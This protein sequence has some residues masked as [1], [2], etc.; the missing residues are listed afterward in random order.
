MDINYGTRENDQWKIELPGVRFAEAETPGS[1]PHAGV[2]DVLVGYKYRYLEEA[3]SGFSAS[4][5][6]QFLLPMGNSHLGIGDGNTEF[7]AEFQFGKHY[8][9]EKLF[10]YSQA[11]FTTCFNDQDFN[12][13]D[14]GIAADWK[15][16][17]KFE[18]MSDI[19]G[20]AFPDDHSMDY[21]FVE[22]GLAY[23]FS[24]TIAFIGSAGSSF[25]IRSSNT[26]EFT[27]FLGF[28]FTWGA[29]KKEEDEKASESKEGEGSK[30][31]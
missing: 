12:S 5:Y 2:G 8:C 31:S 14:Y 29:E 4:V 25:P 7:L 6:P 30:S 3:Q 15:V 22:G 26:P 11:G 28:Q 19:G 1:T 10:L 16:T 24:K 18:L 13:F 23:H 20:H 17:E 21:T 9:H 27:S